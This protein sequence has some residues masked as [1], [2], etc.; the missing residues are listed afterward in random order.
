MPVDK[1]DV[2]CELLD[3]ALRLYYEGDSYFASLHLAGAAEE[4]FGVYARRC[5]MESAFTN[6][7]RA[8]TKMAKY[9]GSDQED[10]ESHSIG[11]LMN[12]AKNQTKHGHGAVTFDAAT[13]AKEI[14]DRAVSDYYAL[15]NHYSQLQETELIGR[16]NRELTGAA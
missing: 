14:L 8:A 11:E 3:R 9:F 7:R 12:R 13:E 15:M 2:A 4:I 10:S 5:G 6:F 16:F 1:L